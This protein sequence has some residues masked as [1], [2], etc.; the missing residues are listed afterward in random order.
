MEMKTE[1]IGVTQKSIINEYSS[2]NLNDGGKLEEKTLRI[3][4]WHL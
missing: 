1:K 2:S 4:K 3:E